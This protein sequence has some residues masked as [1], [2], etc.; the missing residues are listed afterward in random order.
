MRYATWLPFRTI[1]MRGRRTETSEEPHRPQ[2]G[3]CRSVA[4]TDD[5]VG[6]CPAGHDNDAVSAM[7]QDEILNCYADAG[8]VLT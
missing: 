3:Q 7:T 4:S 5:D 6:L 1:S 2:A 8:S